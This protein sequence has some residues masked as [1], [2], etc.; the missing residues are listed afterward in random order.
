M[1]SCLSVIRLDACIMIHI[2]PRIDMEGFKLK[3][4]NENIIDCK[5]HY[6]CHLWEALLQQNKLILER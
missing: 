5:V 2:V 4:I 6:M 3:T 1:I